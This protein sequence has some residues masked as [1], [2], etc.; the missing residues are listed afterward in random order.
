ML[1]QTNTTTK[2]LYQITRSPR[3]RKKAPP[4]WGCNVP[5]SIT[6]RFVENTVSCSDTTKSLVTVS[7]ICTRMLSETEWEKWSHIS[8]LAWFSI[9]YLPFY[10]QIWVPLFQD[11]SCLA[12]RSDSSNWEPE[13]L[14]ASMS[15]DSKIQHALLKDRQNPYGW[16]C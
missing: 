9:F 8:W 4:S 15:T 6:T 7:S 2:A 11:A 3:R 5:K 1:K 16:R 14:A 13:L 10:P 12:L